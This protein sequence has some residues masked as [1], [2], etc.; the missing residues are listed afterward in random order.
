MSSSWMR[1]NVNVR[2]YAVCGIVPRLFF[3]G[4]LLLRR[5]GRAGVR[6][7]QDSFAIE[8]THAILAFPKRE[9]RGRGS[10]EG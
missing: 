5:R 10:R 2:V 4:C 1:A 6:T 8:R 9:L 7:A 3:C